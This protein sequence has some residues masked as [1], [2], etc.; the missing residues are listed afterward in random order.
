[1]SF[2]RVLP[3]PLAL[4]NSDL[5]R[6]WAIE[7]NSGAL[8]N[9]KTM[10]DERS[11]GAFKKNAQIPPA[12]SESLRKSSSS[13]VEHPR[14]IS[15]AEEED[16]SP[17]P[18]QEIVPTRVRKPAPANIDTWQEDS[19][20]QICLC[21]PDPKVPRPRNGTCSSS[22]LEQSSG[23]S[24]LIICPCSIHPLPSTPPSFSRRSASRLSKS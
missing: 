10:T 24:C 9:A 20:S 23:K 19:P 16:Q 8:S 5:A 21:Q 7:P 12:S 15:I 6:R 1:M 13:I 14:S 22:G 18:R 2:H 17:D 4:S 11:H 3:S